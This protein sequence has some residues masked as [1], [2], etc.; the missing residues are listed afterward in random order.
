MSP[1]SV[2]LFKIS[3]LKLLPYIATLLLAALLECA[4]SA[5]LRQSNLAFETLQYTDGGDEEGTAPDEQV[6]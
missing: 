2:E 5:V 6:S 3:R 1:I 4:V